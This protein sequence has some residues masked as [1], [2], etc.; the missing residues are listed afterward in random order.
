M[1]LGSNQS[2]LNALNNLFT[3]YRIL[4]IVLKDE[5]TMTFAVKL[6]VCD[7]FNIVLID[8]AQLTRYIVILALVNVQYVR[9][10][11]VCRVSLLGV[12]GHA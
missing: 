5:F 3:L 9:W 1:I 2:L 8:N 4:Q 11:P 10:L 7:L 12:L 6:K